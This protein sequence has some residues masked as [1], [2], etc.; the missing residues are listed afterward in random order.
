MSRRL[1]LSSLPIVTVMSQDQDSPLLPALIAEIRHERELQGVNYEELSAATGLH[2]TTLALYERGERGPTVEAAIQIAAALGLPLS[3]LL[4]RAEIASKQA[5]VTEEFK[6]KRKISLANFK[7]AN[8][9]YDLTGLSVDTIRHGIFSCYRIL[10]AIDEQLINHGVGTISQVVELANLSSMI[11]NILAS[12]LSEASN[13][14]YSRNRPHAFPDLIPLNKAYDD[15]EL[16]VAFEKNKPKGHLPKSGTY[17]TFRY[18]LCDARG[19]Y[20]K[21]KE[22]RGNK[23]FI[24]EVKVGKVR[25]NDFDLSSTAGDSGKTAVIKTTVFNNMSLIYYV[26]DLLPYSSRMLNYPGFN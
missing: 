11:G 22:N 5:S 9:L 21:G 15:L 1:Y 18:V 20:T 4:R 8:R 16:K 7:N 13:G 14:L 19:N 26:R 6:T 24:W 2:R 17:I 23:V 3:E 10:D 12:G 25:E